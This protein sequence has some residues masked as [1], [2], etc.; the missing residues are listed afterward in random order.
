MNYPQIGQSLCT[1]SMCF[2]MHWC[3]LNRAVL[4]PNYHLL[5]WAISMSKYGYLHTQMEV[6]ENNMCLVLVG[7]ARVWLFGVKSPVNASWISIEASFSKHNSW[8]KPRSYNS[9]SQISLC[10][11]NRFFFK[12][13]GLLEWF[14]RQ[15][16]TRIWCKLTFGSEVFTNMLWV[17]DVRCNFPFPLKCHWK[18]YIVM[19][20]KSESLNI[21]GYIGK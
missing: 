17:W 20:K 14:K 3:M 16:F 7:P 9:I 15:H 8:A 11:E 6:H 2:F 10:E 5:A 21:Q 19:K 12:G 1:E 18:G 4:F 13:L